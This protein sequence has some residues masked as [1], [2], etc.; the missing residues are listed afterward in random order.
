MLFVS[1][2][3]FSLDIPIIYILVKKKRVITQRQ[4][5]YKLCCFG[6]KN[7]K[8]LCSLGQTSSSNSAVN[9]FDFALIGN[10]PS[11]DPKFSG[12]FFS[13]RLNKINNQYKPCAYDGCMRAR[14]CWISA[15]I[16]A[17]VLSVRKGG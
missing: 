6:D 2:A 14:Q 12:S 13:L 8:N 5:W 3:N 7:A 17:I 4:L 16:N 10:K 11:T 9:H 15:K 1:V